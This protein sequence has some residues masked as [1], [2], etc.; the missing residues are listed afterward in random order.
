MGML[1]CLR[2]LRPGRRLLVTPDR[3]RMNNGVLD[4]MV[5]TMSTTVS[6]ELLIIGGGSAGTIVAN[7][8]AGK[9]GKGHLAVIEP[10]EVRP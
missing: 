6:Y 10:S 4:Q 7:K 2:S 1:R 9:L 3:C 8:F 5:V